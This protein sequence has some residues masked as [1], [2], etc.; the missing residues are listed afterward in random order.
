MLSLAQAV[1]RRGSAGEPLPTV[2]QSLAH[3]GAYICKGQVCTIAGPPSAGKSLL[4]F[5]LLVSMGVPTLAFLLDADELTATARFASIITG[6]PFLDIRENIDTYRPQLAERL[7]HIQAHFYASDK[8]DLELQLDAYEQRFGLPPDVLVLDN[9]GNISSGFENEW[10]VIK[11]M[12]VELD[13]LAK[14]NQMAVI[15]THHMTDV[16]TIVP[17][18]RSK[19]LGKGSQY[20]RLILSTA[21]DP[22]ASELKVAVVKASSGPSDTKALHPITLYADPAR[23]QLTEYKAPPP[24][25]SE[26][27]SGGWGGY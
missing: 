24:A 11:A 19:M 13:S 16:E 23:M 7:P 18:P 10:A 9:I 26:R 22:Y 8:S 1:D 20:Q 17:L 4:V 5:N 21:F 27:P 25:P 2:Y 14:R 12:L 3:Q 6:D 15:V